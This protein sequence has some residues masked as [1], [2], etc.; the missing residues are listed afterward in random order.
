VAATS[1]IYIL[2]GSAAAAKKSLKNDRKMW[3]LGVFVED[4]S[5]KYSDFKVTE[6]LG[7]CID[8]PV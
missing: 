3:D 4:A 5:V 8:Q 6:A 7:Y 2:L 1:V